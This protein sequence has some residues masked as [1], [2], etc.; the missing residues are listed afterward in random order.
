MLGSRNYRALPFLSSWN[1]LL[2]SMTSDLQG[3]RKRGKTG[4]GDAGCKS[5]PDGSN[6]ASEDSSN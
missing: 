6:A 3:Q 1:H 2:P 5:G 4:R